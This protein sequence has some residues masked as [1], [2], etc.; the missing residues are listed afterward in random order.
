MADSVNPDR[1]DLEQSQNNAMEGGCNDPYEQQLLA[2]FESCLSEGETSLDENGLRS[3]CDKLQLEERGKELISCLLERTPVRKSV[4]FLEFRDGLLALLGKSQEGGSNYAEKEFANDS[5][6]TLNAPKLTAKKYGRTTKSKE[7]KSDMVDYQ[8]ASLDINLDEQRLRDLWSKLNSNID[9]NTDRSELCVISQCI[10]IPTLSRQTIQQIFERLDI[11]RDGQISFDDFS[12]LFRNEKALQEQVSP[13]WSDGSDINMLKQDSQKESVQMI[14]P[15]QTG[16]VRSS[17]VIDMWEVAGVHEATTLLSD[18]GFTS[19]DVSLTELTNVLC[20]ELKNLRDESDNRVM[21]THVSLLKAALVIYQ[22]EVRSLNTL[23]EHLSC[24]RDKLRIDITEASE[25]A[26]LLAQEIDEHHVRLETSS[27][28]QLK[29]LE[30]KHAE[31]TKELTKQLRSEREANVVTLKLMDERLQTLQQEDQRLKN[32]LINVLQENQTLEVENQN[33]SDQV[34]SLKVS[35]NQLQLQIQTLAAEHDV[36]E[37][38]EARENEQVISLIDRIQRLQSD[39]SLL[40]DQNDEL[41]SE[42]ELLKTRDQSVKNTRD[43]VTSSSPIKTLIAEDNEG[44]SHEALNARITELERLLKK[45]ESCSVKEAESSKSLANELEAECEE[46]TSESLRDLV[47]NKNDKLRL[48]K[49]MSNSDDMI[50]NLDRNFNNLDVKSVSKNKM[51]S[52][53]DY[54][55]RKEEPVA[56]QSKVEIDRAIISFNLTQ[57]CNDRSVAIGQEYVENIDRMNQQL[58]QQEIKH[59]NERKQLLERCAELEKSLELIK[60]EYE[61]CEDYWGNKLEEER[62]LFEQEQKVSDEK[63]SELIAKMAEYEE[64]FGTGDKGR[65]DG[66]LSP[67]EER[68]NLEQQYTDLEEEFEKWKGQA[69]NEI[70]QRDKEIQELH[71]KIRKEKQ[72]MQSDFSTQFPDEDSDFMSRTNDTQNYIPLVPYSKE[73]TKV[74]PNIVSLPSPSQLLPKPTQSVVDDNGLIDSFKLNH[75]LHTTIPS[76][77]LTVSR[78]TTRLTSCLYGCTCHQIETYSSAEEL[79]KAHR[80][81]IRR[82]HQKKMNIDAECNSLIKQKEMLMQEILH[83]QNIRSVT[84]YCPQINAGELACRID[85]NVLQTL[86]TRLQA[87]EQKCKHLQNSLKQQQKHTERILHQTWKQNGKELRD[88]Q[89][90]L[91]STQEK[92]HQQIQAYKEQSEKL[93]RADLLAKDLY[94]ENACLFANVERLEQRCHMLTQFSAESTSV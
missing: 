17:I 61:H 7:Q 28:Y 85:I 59:A 22:E 8:H 80:D 29:Q 72:S 86:N 82:L 56:D 65:N 45:Y 25:R 57:T 43:A 35:N 60:T 39:V 30:I 33:L 32:E 55:P 93:A 91:R 50:H 42:L 52:L 18:L 21:G 75:T 87:Q 54:P 1:R 12:L 38:V 36:V 48:G 92:L 83:L 71:E 68:F 37:N 47:I 44:Q 20:E 41:A 77:G 5:L 15:L 11:D 16:Y 27:R 49:R 6:Q 26:N 62:Q 90:V 13:G 3:L 9:G 64:Q 10:G 46:R 89:F 14:G 23:V 40:R 58:Q 84:C 34:S 74:M 66:R 70:R 88:L 63:F 53:R 79:C 69:E 73:Y 19:P 51:T 24:E 94:V 2:V 67:I 81:E 4:S 78:T 31:E 76:T